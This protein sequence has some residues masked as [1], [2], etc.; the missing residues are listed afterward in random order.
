MP[1]PEVQNKN[2][3]DSEYRST[4]STT[5]TTTPIPKTDSPKKDTEIRNFSIFSDSLN[6]DQKNQLA[7]DFE[8]Y[9]KLSDEEK[10]KI[11]NIGNFGTKNIRPKQNNKIPSLGIDLP[12]FIFYKLKEKGGAEIINPIYSIINTNYPPDSLALQNQN[13]MQTPKNSIK[14]SLVAVIKEELKSSASNPKY[15]ELVQT[16]L[17]VIQTPQIKISPLVWGSLIE[18]K[19]KIKRFDPP[20]LELMKEFFEN[21]EWDDFIQ[22]INDNK[23]FKFDDDDEDKKAVENFNIKSLNSYIKEQTNLKLSTTDTFY[24]RILVCLEKMRST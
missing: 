10:I 9:T 19:E 17:N 5:T 21:Q 22:V 16:I 12:Y 8:E 3:S 13:R 14:N 1:E 18:N 23:D 6:E 24:E 7:K 11:Y 2:Q 20:I 4:D 15:D